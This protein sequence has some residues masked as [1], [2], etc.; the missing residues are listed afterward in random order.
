MDNADIVKRCKFL[1]NSGT[2]EEWPELIDNVER[3]ELQL[4]IHSINRY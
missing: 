3:E 2:S 1:Q 4:H